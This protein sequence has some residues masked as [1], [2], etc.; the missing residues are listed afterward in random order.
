M[1][2]IIKADGSV[3][4]PSK[5]AS[6]L[7]NEMYDWFEERTKNHVKL[8]RKYCKKIEEHDPDRFKGIVERGKEHDESKYEDPEYDPYVLI[9]WR[10]KCKKDGKDFWDGLLSKDETREDVEEEMLKASEH[11]VKNNRHHPEFHTDQEGQLINDKDRDKPLVLV[12]ATKMGD[13]DVAEMCADWAAMS[14]ETGGA[15]KEWADKNVNV[16]W[17]FTDVQ[18]DLIYELI[19]VIWEPAS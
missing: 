8:V 10:Y 11:H 19:E 15:P 6:E 18:K 3:E 16:R 2:I 1:G 13:L 5:K 12:D 17:K 9:T 14:E 4:N 7:F